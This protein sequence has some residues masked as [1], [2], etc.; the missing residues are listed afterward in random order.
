MQLS[1]K[2]GF[3]QQTKVLTNIDFFVPSSAVCKPEGPGE[4]VT[5]FTK[6]F[7]RG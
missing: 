7:D 1:I 2:H 3:N 4:L 6:C 5:D